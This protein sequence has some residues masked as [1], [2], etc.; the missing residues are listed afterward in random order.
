M[1]PKGVYNRY[2][3]HVYT[4]HTNRHPHNP[5]CIYTACSVSSSSLC[6]SIWSDLSSEKMAVTSTS[7][8][9]PLKSINTTSKPFSSS[10]FSNTATVTVTSSRLLKYYYYSSSKPLQ[11]F[12]QLKP[13]SS[14][15]SNCHHSPSEWVL[16]I[17]SPP[18]LPPSQI[19]RLFRRPT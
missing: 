7:V 15:S 11:V 13:E 3:A 19:T 16:T 2:P 10:S 12:C 6:F 14:S 18:S 8:I 5:S 1:G 4:S 17:T 9:L